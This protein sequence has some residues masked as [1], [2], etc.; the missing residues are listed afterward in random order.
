MC[1]CGCERVSALAHVAKVKTAGVVVSRELTPLL[2]KITADAIK[3]VAVNVGAGEHSFVYVDDDGGGF[4]CGTPP[5]RRPPIPF[6]R[7]GLAEA[8]KSMG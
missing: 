4:T 7:G 1:N 5:G 6:P 2:T 3:Q 8:V